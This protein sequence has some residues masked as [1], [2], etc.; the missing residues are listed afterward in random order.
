[1]KFTTL[2]EAEAHFSPYTPLSTTDILKG[3][4]YWTEYLK[5]PTMGEWL[6]F[7]HVKRDENTSTISKPILGLVVGHSIWDMA[8]VLEYVTEWRAWEHNTEVLNPNVKCH[9]PI[10]SNDKTVKHIQLWT[11]NI[12]VIGH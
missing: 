12:I 10:A 1:M 3:M 7:K 11:D 9:Y 5:K 8:L 2:S 6:L 4:C